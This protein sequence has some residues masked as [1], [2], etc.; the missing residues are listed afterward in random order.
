MSRVAPKNGVVGLEIVVR[1]RPN[2]KGPP[3]VHVYIERGSETVA[4][5]YLI[6]P[7]Q[8]ITIRHPSAKASLFIA[9][10]KRPYGHHSA[11]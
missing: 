1:E 6:P 11:S 2:P 10:M 4:E 9:R 8:S 3:D 5:C 7:F